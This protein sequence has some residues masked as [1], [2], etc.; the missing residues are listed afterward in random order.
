[1]FTTLRLVLTLGLA[2]LFVFCCF[3]YLASFEPPVVRAYQLLYG[4]AALACV[5]AIA[6]VW[7]MKTRGR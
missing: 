2:A 1:M 5:L 4:A 7:M 3:G 6:G